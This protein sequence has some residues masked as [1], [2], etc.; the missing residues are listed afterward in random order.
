M[1][2]L[3]AGVEGCVCIPGPSYL[4][5]FHACTPSWSLP[6]DTGEC[7]PAACFVT[8]N[9]VCN[10]LIDPNPAGRSIATTRARPGL[11]D[12]G[13]RVAPGG[14]YS[15]RPHREPKTAQT[16]RKNQPR[17]ASTHDTNEC[18]S[19]CCGRGR[20]PRTPPGAV[21]GWLGSGLTSYKAQARTWGRKLHKGWR[22][23]KGG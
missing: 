20:S 10:R 5:P 8:T 21:T 6:S 22:E 19:R 9:D 7:W 3:H 23:V 4:G 12:A 15:P 13:G 17:G 11:L 18:I 16:Q 2:V 14:A 1:A